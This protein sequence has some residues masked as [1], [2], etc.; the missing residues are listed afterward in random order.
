MKCVECVRAIERGELL[1]CTACKGTFHYRCLNITTADFRENSTRIRKSFKCDSC[2]SVTRRN[3]NDDTPIRKGPLLDGS[4][5]SFEGDQEGTISVPSTSRETSV[6]ALSGNVLTYEGL[7]KLLDSKLREQEKSITTKVETSL[8]KELNSALDKLKSEFTQ[9]TDFLAAEQVDLREDIQ[10]TNEKVKLLETQNAKLSSEIIALER[11][12]RPIEKYSRS[13]NLELHCVPETKQENSLAILKKLCD[14]VGAPLMESDISS[15]RR[16]SKMYTS[17]SRPRNLLATLKSEHLRDSVISAYKNYN[18]S[19]KSEPLNTSQL[20]Y[21]G[22]STRIFVVE[23][24]SPD[25]KELHARTRALAKER[26]YK[27]VWIH[28]GNICVRKS[29]DSDLIVVK[30]VSSLNKLV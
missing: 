3:R 16:I 17:S 5:K 9:T 26:K 11:R 30:D 19:H 24:L 18:K 1:S 10:A 21:T 20:G 28:H 25:M 8:K 2:N 23:H 29:D 15:V 14:V 12:L 4:P 6:A 7:S 22:D 13:C 27:H